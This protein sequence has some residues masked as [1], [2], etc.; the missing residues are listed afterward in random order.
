MSDLLTPVR[1][2]FEWVD[3]F[4]SSIALRESQY[5]WSWI[6]VAHVIG[7]CMFAGLLVMMDLRLVGRAHVTL[8]FSRLQRRLFAWQMGGMAVS[9]LTGI[10]LVYAQPMRYYGSVFFWMKMATMG[11]AALNAMAFHY[12]VYATVDTW[13]AAR[14]TPSAARLAGLFG[15][16]LWAIVV[17]EGRLIPYSLTWFPQE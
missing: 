11:L 14:R 2:L 16:V 17:V 15:I 3:T 10:A 13:D 6:V 7:V 8:P 4:P 5:L 9:F 12:G 1:R